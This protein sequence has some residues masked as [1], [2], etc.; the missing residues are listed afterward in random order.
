MPRYSTNLNAS[1]LCNV[2]VQEYRQ[3]DREAVWYLGE[4][5]VEIENDARKELSNW[6]GRTE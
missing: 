4:V 5:T 2:V 3:R 6:L 1:T